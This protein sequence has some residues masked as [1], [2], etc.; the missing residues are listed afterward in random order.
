MPTNVIMPQLGES[1]VE[2]TI[3]RW[4]VREGDRVEKYAQLLEV[5]TDKVDTEV[6]APVSGTVLKIYFPEG[7]T[8]RAGTVIAVI[9][10]P[11][12]AAP[13]RPGTVDLHAEP[14]HAA[15]VE[16]SAPAAAPPPPRDLGR[17]SPVVAR[18]AREHQVDLYQVK[19]TGREGRI[20]KQDV[21]AY[22]AAR[23]QA[24][25]APAPTPAVQPAEELAPWERPG[26][27]DLFKPTDELPLAE[28]PKPP[29]PSPV[30]AP[31]GPAEELIPHS[32]LRRLIAEH[33]V[34]S[35]R[36]SPHVTTVMEA[37][38]TAVV[39]H[40]AAHKAQFAAQGVNLTFTPYF[41]QAIVAG[42]KAVP[43]ANA[44]WRE[45]GLLIQRRY[46]IGMAVAV[47]DGLIVPVIHNADELSLLGLARQVNDLAQ[48]A[49]EGRLKPDEIK[50]ATFTL[51]NHGTSG[52][53]FATPIIN[54]PNVG[55][56][57]VGAIQKRAVVISRGHPIEPSAE[58]YIAIRPMAYLS[59]TFDHRVL[60]G[61]AADA[62]L[63]VVKRT[64]E[65]WR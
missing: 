44:V 33:M 9:G 25:Q 57:G 3:S 62:F 46:H 23:D 6:P 5:S 48:R 37:D 22:I 2:G 50:G 24:A 38:M 39:A 40:R 21:L 42:L 41:I 56:L 29:A 28:P 17:I 45:D 1:V 12:E 15:E 52:S 64:L 59:F 43:R 20:T 8:V 65:E 36:T 26:S 4:L 58:D 27:G 63:A 14:G 60:D 54:Q 11:G 35:K 51:T 49:R 19:G 10:Q 7:A 13:D 30:T 47:E 32:R 55:I 61:A 34:A 16:A 53:L 18:I 31:A